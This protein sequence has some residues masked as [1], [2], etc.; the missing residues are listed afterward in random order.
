MI[1][2]EAIHEQLSLAALRCSTKTQSDADIN[3]DWPDLEK[4]ISYE[5]PR[6]SDG[7]WA[8]V[9]GTEWP[10]NPLR[11]A[12]ST[13]GFLSFAVQMAM[14]CAKHKF[15]TGGLVCKS[16][17]NDMQFVHA[18]ATRVGETAEITQAL[19][20]EWIHLLY[21]AILDPAILDKT[22]GTLVVPPA[23]EHIQGAVAPATDREVDMP[24]W[25][26]WSLFSYIRVDYVFD[27]PD[28]KSSRHPDL[29]DHPS[30]FLLGVMLHTIQ[31][32]Y[33]SAHN[34]SGTPAQNGARV[35]CDKIVQFYTCP[36]Q[37]GKKHG[38]ADKRPELAESCRKPGRPI[39][40]PV[41]AGARIIRFAR[42]AAPW[43]DVQEYLMHRVFDIEDP[44]AVSSNGPF[45][46]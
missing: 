22:L 10:D 29:R 31:D 36:G 27:G 39:D 12:T 24:S 8:L 16:H 3:C 6:L 4:Y 35:T 20:L 38:K 14:G 1:N 26:A 17:Y 32:S 43:A 45:K 9:R 44:N 18:M 25:L 41:T 5:L 34:Q 21:A 19:I 42:S 13:D 30:E 28:G 37:S 7:D 33:S 11:T 2:K 15:P 46:K 23:F 40:D